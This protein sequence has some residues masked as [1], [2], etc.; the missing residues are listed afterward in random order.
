MSFQNA[1]APHQS[2]IKNIHILNSR[3]FLNYNN[4]IFDN[5]LRIGNLLYGYGGQDMGFRKIFAHKARLIYT[6]EI[7]KNGFV[8]YSRSHVR[9]NTRIG[10]LEIGTAHGFK[11]RPIRR[12]SLLY[13]TAL[14]AYRYL[15]ND[16]FIYYKGKMLKLLGNICM[17][18]TAVSLDGLED[19]IKVDGIVFDIKMSSVIADSSIEKRYIQ[20][21]EAV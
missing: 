8:G 11:C 18:Y 6:T 4:I 14:A 2:N 19:L 7:G 12:R 10:I 15:K 3:G 20:G 17:S 21:G 16:S 9:K 1:V 13:N 5:C